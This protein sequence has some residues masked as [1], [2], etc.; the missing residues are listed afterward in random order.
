M[1]PFGKVIGDPVVEGAGGFD[2]VAVR[3]RQIGAQE[4]KLLAIQYHFVKFIIDFGF[5]D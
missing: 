5:L 2:I 3:E 4:G 1:H